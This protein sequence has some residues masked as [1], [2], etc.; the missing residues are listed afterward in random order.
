LTI[1]R[2][3]STAKRKARSGIIDFSVP[4]PLDDHI[5]SILDRVRV[6]VSGQLEADLSAS[7]ADILRAVAEEHRQTIID[8]T[9]RTATEVRLEAE[10]RL[11][12][13]REEF[14]RER[15]ELRQSAA[16][17]ASG[18][19]QALGDV[20]GELDAARRSLDALQS[21]RDVMEQELE[22]IKQD[23]AE[24]RRELE[25]AVERATREHEQTRQESEAAVRELER[26]RTR[27]AQTTRLAS[28]FRTLDEATSLGDILEHLA[29]SACQEA[30]RTAVFLV[31]GQ[32][33]R[34]WRALGFEAGGEPIVGA[35]FEPDEAGV[36]G[37]AARLG[38]GQQHR[39]GDE[40]ALPSFAAVNEARDA[41]AI[42]V[43][44]G[45]SVI[46]VLYADAA[47]ADSPEEPEWLD[48][49]DAMAKHAGRVLE[50]M[51][52]RQAAALWAPRPSVGHLA[53]GGERTS[54]RVE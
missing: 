33:L 31:N 26:V 40:T 14:E 27:L 10:G 5:R 51:T 8:A 45:G 52:V 28:A 24:R 2:P 44:V 38:M 3:S 53:Q 30:G 12:A 17:E 42:P 34:A 22:H 39:N 37:Q 19:A 35:D 41:V 50:A 25:E 18:L 6:T 32:K 23:W 21:A 4:S 49:I 36:V 9:E 47:R 15:E 46:A 1:A 16:T 13:A 7:T 48:L 29:E 54:A 20:R 11:S 43:Q